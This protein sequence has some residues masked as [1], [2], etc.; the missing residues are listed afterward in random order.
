MTPTTWDEVIGQEPVVRALRTALDRGEVAHAW[1]FVGP[2]GV[3]QLAVANALA[4]ALNC[5]EGEGVEGCGT[6]SVCARIGRGTHPA[7]RT[8]EPEGAMHVVDAVREEWIP[9]AMRT[10]TEGRRK[11]LRVAAAER[12]NEA[13]QNAFLKV[14]EEPP[15]SVVW[16]LDAEDDAALLDTIVS[17]CRRL[18]FVPW[19]PS[20]LE[21][22]AGR[23][24][25]PADRRPVLAR[26]A[27]GSP[28]RLRDLADPEIA[29]ARD[30]H[31][32]LVGR[33]HSEGPGAVVPVAKELVD[34]TKERSKAAKERH[35]EEME[36]LEEAYGVEDGRGWPPGVKQRL[37][38]RFHRLEREEQRRALDTVLDDLASWLRDCLAATSGGDTASFVN[39]DRVEEARVDA[40]RLGAPA[41]LAGLEAVETCREALDRN[42]QPQVQLE[43]LLMALALPLYARSA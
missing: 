37:T 6:C 29:A 26:A 43:R 24:E 20:D 12:M 15:P 13:A 28:E 32:E 4:A 31:L 11:V 39:L 34:W 8:F 23:L 5:P 30:R 38:K 36:R 3:G 2:H 17:R 27:M 25:V 42:G 40:G 10:Q 33:L 16:L 14:L 1:L 7:V 9:V 22:L 21:E 19:G 18:D 35:V 41:I